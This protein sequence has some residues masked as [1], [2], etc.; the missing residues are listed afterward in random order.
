MNREIF[1]YCLKLSFRTAAALL[2]GFAV[3]SF[4]IALVDVLVINK[5]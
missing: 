1:E 5:L 3:V 4:I 2:V